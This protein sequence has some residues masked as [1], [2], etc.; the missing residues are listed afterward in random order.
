MRAFVIALPSEADAVR[1]SLGPDDRLYVSGVGKANAAAETQR[2]IDGG[3]T[4]IVN[5]GLC[6]G[7]GESVEIGGCYAVRFAVEYDFDLAALNGTRVGQ[8]NER[9]SPYIPV[10]PEGLILGTGDRF[11]DSDADFGLLRELGCALRDMEGAA[12]AHVCEKRGVPCRMLKCVSDLLG[13]DSPTGQ[14]EANRSDCLARLR[15]AIREW[16]KV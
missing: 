11:G 3:A 9:S 10:G 12:I 8:L 7:F 6:G 4:E 2:A 15:E 1:P 13:C 5:A 16:R 14:Y